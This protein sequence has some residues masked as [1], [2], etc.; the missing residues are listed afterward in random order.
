MWGG[1]TV[2]ERAH[3]DWSPRQEFN[4][5]AGYFFTPLGIWN[6]D[7]GSPTLISTMLP[8]MIAQKMFPIRQTGLM[9]YGSTFAGPWELGYTATFSNGRQE[10]S[11]FDFDDDKAFGARLFARNEGDIRS[12][13]GASFY[14]GDNNDKVVDLVGITPGLTFRDYESFRYREWVVGAD[15]SIDIGATRIRT[16][17]LI[18]RVVYDRGKRDPIPPIFAQGA[19]K[20]DAYNST[21]YLLVA[22]QLPWA[23]IEPFLFTEIVYGQLTFADSLGLL[24]GGVNVHFTPA[25]MLKMQLS[26]AIFFNMRDD[27][28]PNPSLQNTTVLFSRLVLAY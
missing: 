3:I 5:R 6:V 10:L 24:S 25:T 7:H 22:H 27:S 13:F 19:F 8:Q 4:V 20:P 28:P 12:L 15:A 2:I 26:R 17:G 11:T 9:V 23:G 18:N 1:Y 21:A 14:T 16:E